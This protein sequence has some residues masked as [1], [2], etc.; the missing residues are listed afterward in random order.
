[1]HDKNELPPSV[2]LLRHRQQRNDD[3]RFSEAAAQSID[4]ERSAS[5]I[6]EVSG[7]DAFRAQAPEIDIDPRRAPSAGLRPTNLRNWEGNGDGPW[8]IR[9][10]GAPDDLGRRPGRD[11]A[12]FR[13]RDVERVQELRARCPDRF[14]RRGSRCAVSGSRGVPTG[15]DIDGCW[16]SRQ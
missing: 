9:P 15:C 13:L 8:R 12:L 1:M 10:E 11:P 4:F 6:R 2:L 7:P 3:R 14:A 5:S 16:S